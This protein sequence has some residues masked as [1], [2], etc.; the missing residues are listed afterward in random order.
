MIDMCALY[1]LEVKYLKHNKAIVTPSRTPQKNGCHER[2]SIQ[3]ALRATGN[4]TSAYAN[5]FDFNLISVYAIKS[6]H[7]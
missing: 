1:A 7:N 2:T 5:L 3:H 6:P 4:L